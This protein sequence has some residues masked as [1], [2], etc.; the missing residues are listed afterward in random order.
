MY[1]V[2]RKH[3]RKINDRTGQEEQGRTD[4]NSFDTKGR[5]CSGRAFYEDAHQET[6]R[7]KKREKSGE[8]E[9]ERRK[10]SRACVRPST[11]ND[12]CTKKQ[13]GSTAYIQH[14]GKRNDASSRGEELDDRRPEKL[15]RV[16]VVLLRLPPDR[17]GDGLEEVGR[18]LGEALA[19]ALVRLEDLPGW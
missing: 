10:Y 12:I 7:E 2:Y 5:G 16:S 3:G 8:R 11:N 18:K 13:L 14:K 4:G 17:G 19:H 1:L 9:T 15:P 6:E